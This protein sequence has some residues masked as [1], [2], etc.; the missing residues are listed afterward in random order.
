MGSNQTIQLFK[1][2]DR[3]DGADHRLL[4]HWMAWHCLPA[5]WFI[6]RFYFF[7]N[8]NEISMKLLFIERNGVTQSFSINTDWE[9]PENFKTS[10][11]LISLVI[12]TKEGGFI[13]I[14][15]EILLNS[16]IYTKQ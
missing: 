7:S 5:G 8:S 16:I 3:V 11:E 2:H 13:S 9:L 4:V 14:G 6:R 1:M 10:S 12:R 15:K